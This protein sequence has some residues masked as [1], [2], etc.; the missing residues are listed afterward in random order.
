MWVSLVAHDPPTV[1]ISI[2]TKGRGANRVK[3]DT[4]VNCEETGELVVNMISEWYIEAANHT[5]GDFLS[6]VSEIDVAGLTCL[7]STVV[8][9]PRVAEAA[10]QMECKI[11]EIRE[12]RNDKDEVMNII[13]K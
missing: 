7:E 12:I 5:C 13:T 11:V 2:C 6:E 4:L 10:V 9:C 3:K 8:K 1:S